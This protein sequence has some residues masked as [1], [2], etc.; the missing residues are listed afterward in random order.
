LTLL[1]A[2]GL[3]ALIADEPAADEVEGLLR[4]GDCRVVAVNLAEAIDVCRR[5]HSISSAD[6]GDALRPLTLSGSLAVAASDE[7]AAWTAADLLATH[8]H[9]TDCPVSLADCFLLAHALIDGDAIATSDPALARAARTESSS[10][11]AL[12]DRAGIRP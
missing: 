11:V 2:Y 8:Y 7:Q 1:D 6:V 5:V 10:V 12:P 9:R 3:V 4:S